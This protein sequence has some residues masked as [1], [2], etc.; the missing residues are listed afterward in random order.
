MKLSKIVKRVE[1]IGELAS[2]FPV[3]HELCATLEYELWGDVLHATA[4]GNGSAAK[5]YAALET[6]KMK[7]NRRRS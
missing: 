5:A 4:M 6:L 1:Q 3:D 2:Q 7:F